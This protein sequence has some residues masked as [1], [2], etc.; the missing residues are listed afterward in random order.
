MDLFVSAVVVVV[1]IISLATNK[2]D[3]GV[4]FVEEEL[5][6]FVLKTS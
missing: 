4:D 3:Q 5:F 2:L 1:S 6:R